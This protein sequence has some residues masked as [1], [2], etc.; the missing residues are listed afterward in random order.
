MTMKRRLYLTVAAIALAGLLA[1]APA[2]LS[3][4]Y[5]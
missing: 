1:A 4:Q 3:A 5:G 2:Q